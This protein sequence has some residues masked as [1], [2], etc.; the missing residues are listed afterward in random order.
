[1]GLRERF[2][3]FTNGRRAPPRAPGFLRYLTGWTVTLALVFSFTGGGTDSPFAL[4]AR[5]GYW[6]IHI[7]TGLLAVSAVSG[8]LQRGPCA[9]L[10]SIIQLA[11]YGLGGAIVFTPLAILF[12][13]W[14]PVPGGPDGPP[15]WPME[16]ARDGWLRA[17]LAEFGSL[18]PSFLGSWL[19]INMAY[20]V[21]A[22]VATAGA[23]MAHAAEASAAEPPHAGEALAP[24]PSH[25]GEASAPEP[26]NAPESATGNGLRARLPQALGA[27][28]IHLRADLNY[29]HVTTAGGSAMLLYSLA[30]AAEELGGLGL[31]VHRAH[32]VAC[33][34]VARSR[35]TAQGLVLTL[36]NGI[37]VPVSR[38][39]QAEIRTRF[40]DRFQAPVTLHR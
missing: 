1:M 23:P 22:R 29:L 31:I 24:E 38:R 37:D 34:H 2:K 32:W 6:S 18:A 27:D 13:T 40:G 20:L 30:R 21:P 11:I 35:R 12:E 8:L 4:A 36:S 19:L 5:F 10:P 16:A 39:R 9:C 7:G 14:W 15:D 26:P 17:S 3:N 33:A 25:A 28:I